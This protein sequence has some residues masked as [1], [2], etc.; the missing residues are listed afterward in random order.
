MSAFEYESVNRSGQTGRGSIEAADRAEAVRL[1]TKRG[2]IPTRVAPAGAPRPGGANAARAQA[3]VTPVAPTRRDLNRIARTNGAGGS[4]GLRGRMGTGELA[5]LIREIATALEAGLPLMSA[6]RAVAKQA[7]HGKQAALVDHL[8]DRIEAGRSFAQAAAEWGEPFD[9][10]V[11][12]MIRAGE[13]SGRL[14]TVMLQ[15]ADLLDRDA[16]I[17]RSVL[18]AMIYP[19]ILTLLLTA[20]IIVMVTFTFPKI[21]SALQGQNF[22]MPLPTRIVQGAAYV[23]GTYWYLLV[24]GAIIAFFAW[25]AAMARPEMRLA[26]D[27]FLLRVPGVGA[28]LRDMAVGR[29]TRTFGTLL[30]SGIPVL[31]A[32][33]ITKDT[34]GNKALESVMDDVAEQVRAGK[35]IAEPMERSGYFPPLLVQIIGLGERSGRL[36]EMLRQAAVSFDRRTAISVEVFK[37]ILPPVIIVAMGV[38]VAFVLAAVFLAL[39]EMQNAIG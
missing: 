35:S 38:V 26:V 31:D 10:M 36:D 34:L 12:G 21:M 3:K 7:S 5:S 4:N 14:D 18:G 16:D 6:L 22:T 19:A 32:L 8:M 27:R 29:F 13:A 39:L 1:L 15:L 17:R 9:D 11:I 25:R 37:T 28:V 2:E 23:T 20:A 33:L 30:A 24:G